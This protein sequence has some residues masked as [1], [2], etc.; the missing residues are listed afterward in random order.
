MWCWELGRG[1][2]HLLLLRQL[3]EDIESSIS[4]AWPALQSTSA[5][6]QASRSAKRHLESPWATTC[7]LGL[8]SG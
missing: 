7:R 3:N 2:A 4:R 1:H 8:N 6:A 5:A